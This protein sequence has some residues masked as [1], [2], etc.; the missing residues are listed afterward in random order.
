MARPVMKNIEKFLT[1][2]KLLYDTRIKALRRNFRAENQANDA[3]FVFDYLFREILGNEGY[4]INYS[5]DI[6]GDTADFCYVTEPFVDEVIQKCFDLELFDRT[7]FER[8]KIL[9]SRAIQREYQ[10]VF[11]AMKRTAKIDGRYCVL[12]AGINSEETPVF[13]EAPPRIQE[14]TPEISEETPIRERDRETERQRE[15]QKR[16]HTIFLIRI[17]KTTPPNRTIPTSLR[18]RSTSRY[19]KNTGT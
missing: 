13:T 19:S 14:E 8:N 11:A 12:V 2:T 17:R 1:K 6:V 10:N 15:R 18:R 3:F 4:Y 5:K 16:F 9:T 7:Q